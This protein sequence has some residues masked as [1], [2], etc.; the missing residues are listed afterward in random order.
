MD[1]LVAMP[2]RERERER[3]GDRGEEEGR[4]GSL[5]GGAA[6]CPRGKR[7]RGK[8]WWRR[9]A[10]ELRLRSLLLA[11]APGGAKVGW[12]EEAQVRRKKGKAFPFF[13]LL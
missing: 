3:D 12:G 10:L 2:S 4:R 6:G 5:A 9:L 8:R 11:A 1:A 7:R 13:H